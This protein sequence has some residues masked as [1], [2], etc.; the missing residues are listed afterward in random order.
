MALW[1]VVMEMLDGVL[2]AGME[3]VLLH[4]IFKSLL[5]AAVRVVLTV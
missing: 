1:E 5:L 4:T 2:N 3:N